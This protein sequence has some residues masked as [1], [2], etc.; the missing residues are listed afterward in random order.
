MMNG[1]TKIHGA[2]F[3]VMMRRE[4]DDPGMYSSNRL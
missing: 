1:E 4:K 3:C 2:F